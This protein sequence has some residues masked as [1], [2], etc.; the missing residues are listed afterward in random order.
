M[1]AR[2]RRG[3]LS[4][5]TLGLVLAGGAGVLLVLVA[6]LIGQLSSTIDG[7]D[8]PAPVVT[9][10]VDPAAPGAERT[11]SATLYYVAGSGT[12]L[13]P[14]TRNVP[15]GETTAAQARRIAEAQLQPPPEGL[16][17]ALPAGTTVRTVYLTARG[18]AYVDLSAEMIRGH[19]GGSLNEALAVHALVNAMIVNLPDVS[20]VQILVDGQEV[21]SIAGHLDLRYPLRR[22]GEWIR[23]G[24]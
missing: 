10:P 19:T 16:F 18:E 15:Y 2:R 23:K 22:S 11:I 4:A 3:G 5:R 8:S 24:Q 13:V 1:T 17:T 21:D 6:I 7:P 14:V 12:E 9:G 20:A